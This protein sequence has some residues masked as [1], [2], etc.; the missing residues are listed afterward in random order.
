M[1]GSHVA[2]C[3]FSVPVNCGLITL[4]PPNRFVSLHRDWSECL[5]VRFGFVV[6]ALA[7]RGYCFSPAEILRTVDLMLRS[8]EMIQPLVKTKIIYIWE[9]SRER[10]VCNLNRPGFAGGHFV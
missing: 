6:G 3:V 2:H 9:R 10:F 5:G 1:E 4:Q 8:I 7:D